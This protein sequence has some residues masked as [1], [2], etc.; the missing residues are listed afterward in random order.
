MEDKEKPKLEPEGDIPADYEASFLNL[1]TIML[2]IVA[3]VVVVALVYLLATALYGIFALADDDPQPSSPFFEEGIGPRGVDQRVEAAR[4]LNQLYSAQ[5]ARIEEYRWVNEEAGVAGIPI[6]RAMELMVERGGLDF[7]EAAGPPEDIDLDD[8]EALAEFGAQ[9]FEDLGCQ[10]CHTD[11]DTPI[12][13]T[14]IGLFGEERVSDTGEVAVADEEYI[15]LS[16]LEPQ[17]HVTA[18]YQPIMPSFQGRLTEAQLEALIAYI[19]SIG[20]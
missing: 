13:P 11:R 17:T 20:D 19:I 15:R 5:T 18:G 7:G 10:G 8:P 14:L 2:A 6:Q 4:E 9:V 12:A 3:L 16:I 1:R